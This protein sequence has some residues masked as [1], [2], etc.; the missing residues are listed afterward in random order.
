[1]AFKSGFVGVLGRTNVG[2]STLINTL[3]GQKAV[4]VS[5]KPQT[6][7][8]RIRCILNLPHAQLVLIDTPGLHQPA[9]KLS[10]YLIGQALSALRGLDLLLYL[11]EPSGGIH[12]FDE[13]ILPSLKKLQIPRF[14]C[15]TK[16]DQARGNQVLETISRH[17]KSQLFDETIPISSVSGH[18]LDVLMT[19]VEGRL[20]EGPALFP[21]D[22]VVD[23]P[24]HFLAGEL[25]REQVFQLLYQEVPYA[26]A[27]EVYELREREDKPLVEICA[28]IDVARPSQRGILVGEGGAMIKLIGQRA[29]KQIETLLGTHVYLDL[30]VRVVKKW[31]EDP[32]QIERLLGSDH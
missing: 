19:L 26:V 29:R 6:T 21:Q 8:N 17:A 1:M 18:N 13:Q 12:P 4:I 15:I 7:R 24:L 3:L 28:Y 2:K 9:D 23:R 22:Q 20:P 10:K 16:V 30:K 11:V 32:A 5:D 14:L 27:V 31:N 25:I